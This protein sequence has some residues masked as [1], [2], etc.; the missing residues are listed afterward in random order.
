MQEKTLEEARREID[1]IDVQMA[2]LFEKRFH[3]VEDV[4]AWKMTHGKT[5]FDGSR[6]EAIKKKNAAYI[7]D[8]AIRPYFEKLFDTELSLSRAYQ[9]EIAEKSKS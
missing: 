9:K 2:E 3:V 1:E 6:E 8:D 4:I 5:I 7:K